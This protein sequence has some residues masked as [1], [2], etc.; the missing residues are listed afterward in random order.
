[1][2]HKSN[3]ANTFASFNHYLFYNVVERLNS[4]SKKKP[5]CLCSSRIITSFPLRVMEDEDVIIYEWE[6]P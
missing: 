2:I 1:M 6:L 3:N 5:K 4:E